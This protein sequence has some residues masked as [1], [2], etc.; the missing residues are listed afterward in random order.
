MQMLTSTKTSNHFWKTKEIN[1][2]SCGKESQCIIYL[3]NPCRKEAPI[4]LG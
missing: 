2:V 4:C 3:A 1:F